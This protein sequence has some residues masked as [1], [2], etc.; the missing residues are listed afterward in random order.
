MGILSDLFNGLVAVVGVVIGRAIGVAIISVIDLPFFSIVLALI[1]L[2][3][4]GYGL[5]RRKIVVVGAFITGIGLG[6]ASP[7]TSLISRAL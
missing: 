6:I 4:S 7:I 1:G 3:I 5:K 2:V